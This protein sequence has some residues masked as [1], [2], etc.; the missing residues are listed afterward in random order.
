MARNDKRKADG[1][2]GASAH[3]NK[4]GKTSWGKGG[5]RSKPNKYG[6]AHGS[7]VQAIETGDAGIWATCQMGK[8]GKC[9][10][11]LR[12]ILEEYV[13]K[14][15]PAEPP[16]PDEGHGEGSDED[17]DGHED[18]EAAIRKEVQDIKRPKG[19]RKLIQAVKIDV[20]C[21]LFFK[22]QSP[23]DP[24]LVVQSICEDAFSSPGLKR[25]RFL[26]RLTPVSL[27]GRASEEGLEDVARKVLAPHF[28]REDSV[29]KKFAI[30]PSI[31][32]HNTLS[33]QYVI[34]RVAATVGPGHSVDLKNY[35]LLILVDIYKNLCGISVVQT[36]Y[37]RLKRYNLA[38]LYDPTPKPQTQTPVKSADG[39]VLASGSENGKKDGRTNKPDD[40]DEDA[41]SADVVEAEREKDK[42]EEAEEVSSGGGSGP[43]PESSS[44]EEVVQCVNEDTEGG[45]TH[46]HGG[47]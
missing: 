1:G 37:D 27:I 19:T 47:G 21:L 44:K 10:G 38:E 15:Y 32:N 34:D 2:G 20:Q 28:H 40:G 45:E 18:I 35:D 36:G 29:S 6:S 43:R 26:Q 22:V 3:A 33:R 12:E 23:V 13:E 46:G 4:K 30:R 5:K 16:P 39:T 24:V 17:G 14:M 25:S 41:V 8:E 7:D 31:R 9:V 42:E 11:E